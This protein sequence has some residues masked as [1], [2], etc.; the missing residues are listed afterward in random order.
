MSIFLWPSTN[1]TKYNFQQ[2]VFL[3]N[4]TCILSFHKRCTNKDSKGHLP[5]QVYARILFEFSESGSNPS[6]LDYHSLRRTLLP[7]CYLEHLLPW[8]DTTYCLQYNVQHM[9][10]LKRNTAYKIPNL[11]FRLISKHEYA[12]L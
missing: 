6:L 12:R 4:L 11:T 5:V 9:A 10:F 2:T 3:I 8:H 7:F 1:L